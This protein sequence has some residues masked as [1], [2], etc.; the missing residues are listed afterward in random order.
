MTRS[1]C[2][3]PSRT[4]IWSDV[5]VDVFDAQADAVHE[6]EAAAVEQGGHEVGRAVE[7]GEEAL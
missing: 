7:V 3:L 1:F 5:E 2:P 4:V 6:P